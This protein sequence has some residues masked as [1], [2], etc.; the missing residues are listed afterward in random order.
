MTA[1]ERE[2]AG[3]EPAWPD[4]SLPRERAAPEIAPFEEATLD[5]K[6]LAEEQAPPGEVT[7][8]RQTA[9][10]DEAA[11][12]VTLGDKDLEQEPF[13]PGDKPLDEGDEGELEDTTLEDQVVEDEA[14]EEEPYRPDVDSLQKETEQE[15]EIIDRAAHDGKD[16][17][18]ELFEPS[19]TSP[20]EEAL[21]EPT[22]EQD[23]PAAAEA[24][25]EVEELDDGEY[26]FETE[27]QAAEEAESGDSLGIDPKLAT[28]TLATIYKVQ[29]LYH[30]ALQVLDLLEVKGGDPERIQAE[31]ES[32]LQ[33]MT[34][35]T[36]LEPE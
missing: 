34:T 16:M 29:G 28:F 31:R 8:K 18:G 19:V 21:S 1:T 13:E 9:P 30:Q 4:V 20:K 6:D 22:E 5:E 25:P 17:P 27:F 35:G 33:Q 12:R 36:S 15:L 3:E 23:Q 2:D 10:E 11:S 7:D 32:I 24:E 14:E 26:E